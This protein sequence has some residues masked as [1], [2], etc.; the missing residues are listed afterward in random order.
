MRFIIK[1]LKIKGGLH[2]YFFTLLTG[3]DAVLFIFG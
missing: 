3:I 2:S 1:H